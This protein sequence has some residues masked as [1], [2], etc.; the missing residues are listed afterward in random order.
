MKPNLESL[1]GGRAS[2]LAAILAVTLAAGGSVAAFFVSAGG[3]GG[4][5]APLPSPTIEVLSP[6]D[7]TITPTPPAPETAYRLVYQESGPTEDKIWRLSPQDPTHPEHLATIQHPEGLSVRSSLSPDS[8]FIAYVSVPEGAIDASYQGDL[9]T[10]DLKRQETEL[11]HRGVDHRFRPLWS[12]DSRLLFVRRFA[13][14]EVGV[15]MIS[16]ARKPAPDDPTPTATPRT[17]PTPTP[18][19]TPAPTDTPIPTPEGQTPTPTPTPESPVKNILQA[20]MGSVLTFVP[21][22]FADD[23]KSLLFVQVQGGTGGETWVAGYAPAT[24]EGIAEEKAKPTP[25]PTPPPPPDAPLA[26]P[27]P[28]PVRTT[29]IVKLSDQIPDDYDLSPDRKRLS[30]LAPGLA[31]GQF[32]LRSFVADLGGRTVAAV[33]SEGLPPG[34]QLRPLWH[35]DGNRLAV[36]LLPSAIEPGAVALVPA[37]GGPPGFLPAPER[38]FDIPIAWA[39]DGTFLAVTNFSGQSLA[40]P[41]DQRIDLA[42]PTGQRIIVTGG[43][44]FEVIGWSSPPEAPATPAP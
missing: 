12:P 26:T 36:G 29:Y 15:L 27:T 43:P 9:Y 5:S 3:G 13:G 44:Q 25:L 31:D 33:P 16:I 34:D 22:G 14:M 38:G 41:G 2:L 39:P 40:N 17:T 18:V 23:G 8:R 1:P 42:A 19:E 30:F 10:F 32:V 11:V 21:V 20:H 37:G 6:A 35:P 28:T 7:A 4:E 24:T